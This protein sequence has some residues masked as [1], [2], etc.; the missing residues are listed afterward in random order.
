M[1]HASILDFPY[2]PRVLPMVFVVLFFGVCAAVGVHA[3]ASNDRGLI[4][5]GVIQLE[6]AGA[7]CF[8]WG[9]AAVS[10][11]FVAAGCVGIWTGL[12]GKQRLR[13][14]ESERI[15]PRPLAFGRAPERVALRAITGLELQ[16]IQRQRFW[17]AAHAAGKVTIGRS[18]LPDDQAFERIRELLVERAGRA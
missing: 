7:A 15:V 8:W 1:Q 3:A 10:P 16:E 17:V 14:T 18:M 12:F 4:I 9:L 6:E 2:R 5:N 11:A 13:I